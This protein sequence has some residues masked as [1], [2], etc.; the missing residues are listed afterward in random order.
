MDETTRIPNKRPFLKIRDAAKV[1]G[2]SQYF[3]RQGCRNGTIPCLRC[4]TVY[5]V[6]TEGLLEQLRRE[7]RNGGEKS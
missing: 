3:L 2:L 4:G 6:D 7:A 5:M 1:T